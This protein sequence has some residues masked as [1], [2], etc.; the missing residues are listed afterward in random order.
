[1]KNIRGGNMAAICAMVLILC[2]GVKRVNVS[3]QSD[4]PGYTQAVTASGT[5]L[6]GMYNEAQISVVMLNNTNGAFNSGQQQEVQNAIDYITGV[7]GNN[8]DATVA[9]TNTPNSPVNGT[10]SKPV[11]EIQLLNPSTFQTVCGTTSAGACTIPIAVS[12]GTSKGTI[13]GDYI[14][15]STT[16]AGYMQQIILHEFGHAVYGW[17][18]CSNSI[19]CT[20]SIME[21]T[22]Y[23][24]TSPSTLTGCDQTNVTLQITNDGCA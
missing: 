8:Q 18:D 2:F 5:T 23:P 16:W 6:T 21:P 3:A 19:Y 17:A 22:F 14:Y 10:Q 12:S 11:V 20:N 9:I 1:M 15:V 7:N 4:C 13:T 24:E